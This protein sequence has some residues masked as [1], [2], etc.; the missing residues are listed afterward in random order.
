PLTLTNL[1]TLKTS[2]TVICKLKGVFGRHGIPRELISD[3]VPFASAEMARFATKWGFKITHSSPGFPQ[4]NGMAEHCIQTVK[5]MFKATSPSGLDPHL[6]LLTLR[7]TPITG[8][9]YSPAQ[10]LMGRV[11]RSHLPTSPLQKEA[12]DT[13]AAPLHPF[14]VGDKVC[15]DTPKGWQPATVVNVRAEPRAYD[16]ITPE[17][18]EYRRNRKHLRRD[19]T[20]SVTHDAGTPTEGLSVSAQLLPTMA[21]TGKPAQEC[22]RAGRHIRLPT[23]FQDYVL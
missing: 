3:H 12:Y 22:T 16:I 20:S 5:K 15:M 6:A 17:G 13:S 9:K 4:S 23:K 2:S 11:L 10:L 1:P 8:L 7:N 18:A 14:V 21:T 19:R